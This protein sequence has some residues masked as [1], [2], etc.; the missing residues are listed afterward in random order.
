M[1][2]CNTCKQE[3]EDSSFSCKIKSKNILANKCKVC[4]SDYVKEHYLAN[5]KSYKARATKTNL[6]AKKRNRQVVDDLKKIPCMDCGNSYDPICMDFDHLSDKTMSVS[7]LSSQPYSLER[8]NNEI[9]KCE[10]VCSNC[11]RIRTKN[12]RLG[13][14]C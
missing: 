12:R 6:A 1:K 4:H 9:S 5:K 7:K 14:V 3:K 10:I 13:V 11:H 2:T 8:I